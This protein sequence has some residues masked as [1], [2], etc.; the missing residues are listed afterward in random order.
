MIVYG[1]RP[2]KGHHLSLLPIVEVE[3]AAVQSETCHLQQE[4]CDVIDHQFLLLVTECIHQ[5]VNLLSL[6]GKARMIGWL[7]VS[8]APGK[9]SGVRFLRVV[10]SRSLR[11]RHEQKKESCG[12]IGELYA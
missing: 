6:W 3:F 4:L 1:N 7:A 9:A 11:A 2:Y 8:E 10:H 12:S 5:S